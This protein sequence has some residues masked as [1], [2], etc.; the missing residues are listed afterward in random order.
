MPGTALLANKVLQSGAQRLQAEE[1]PAFLRTEAFKGVVYR[2]NDFVLGPVRL[3]KR[4]TSLGAPHVYT[5]SR[6]DR[7]H[8]GADS[9]RIEIGNLRIAC[10]RLILAAGSGNEAQLQRLGF[11]VAMQRRSLHQVV[12]RHPATGSAFGLFLAIA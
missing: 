4:L 3:T 2:L 7:S 5:A 6:I 9:V 11:S 1:S 10:R 12:V 8:D